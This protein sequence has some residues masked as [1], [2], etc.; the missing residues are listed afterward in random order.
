MN[1]IPDC[2]ECGT[3]FENIFEATD[4]LLEDDEDVFD[5]SLILPNGYKLMVGSLLRAIYNAADEPERIKNITQDTYATLYA[6]ETEPKQMQRFIED[7]I[8]NEQMY[9]IDEE[10]EELL[11]D[12]NKGGK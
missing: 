4:H 11:D 9:K 8:I 3:P 6:A 10:L 2:P 5:P 7:L 12:N 1:E